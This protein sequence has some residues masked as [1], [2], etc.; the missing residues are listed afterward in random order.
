MLSSF[1]A[2]SALILCF[3]GV[4]PAAA[5]V[6]EDGAV[7]EEI[8]VMAQRRNE[9]LQNVPV[10]VQAF[11]ESALTSAGVSSTSD[12]V[13][14]AP[15]LTF[16]AQAGWAQPRLRGVGTIALGPGIENPVATY[17]DGVYFASM[18][19][20][21]LDL[22]NVEAVEVINGP[23]GTLFGRNATGGLVQIRTKTPSHNFGGHVS[24]TYGN[25]ETFGTQ[26][27]VTGGLTDK[28]AADL[29]ISYRN[30]GE[31]YGKN[32]FTGT[33]VEKTNNYYIRSKILI[34]PSDMTKI[35]LAGDYGKE[36]FM[37]VLAP[38]PGTIPTGGVPYTGPARGVDGYYDPYG[39][40]TQFGGS[41]TIE[42]DFGVLKLLSITAY[43]KTK[44]HIAFDGALTRDPN[45]ALN[46][47]PVEPH[48]QF[49]QELQILSPDG[50]P[51]T[52]VFGGYYFDE[53]AKFD[54]VLLYGG[55]FDPVR[56]IEEFS[57]SRTSSGSVYGQAT[58]EILPDTN[59]TIGARYI[60]EK[61]KIAIIENLYLADGT[62]IA[63]FTT[64]GA[65]TFQKP[66][67]RVSLDHKITED[68]MAYVSYNRG[69]KSGGF[70]TLIFPAESFA[71]ERLDAYEVGLKT[72]LFDHSLRV[73]TAAFY[74]DYKNIQVA[75]YK[76][77]ILDIYNGAAATLYGLDLDVEWAATSRLTLKSGLSL[78]H[79]TFDDF[80]DA[81][82]TSPTPGG[83][84]TY[85]VGSAKDNKLP[86]APDWTF[87]IAADYT[88][89]TRY[90][91]VTLN[92][93]YL[94]NAG[95]Y[96]EPDNRLSQGAYDVLN[97]QLG[98]TSTDELYEL[99]IWAKNITNEDYATTVFS[100]FNGDVIQYA[101]P[102]TFGVTLKR[103]F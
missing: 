1:R 45:L 94:H 51:I 98:W 101:P 73:N 9:N 36:K 35:T 57:T 93:T 62:N 32:Y 46:I 34:A 81:D 33:E 30:Q 11:N 86:L 27:Y 26:A 77:G 65:K 75:S 21:T 87:N 24:A 78:L 41:A 20:G 92:L 5:E 38:A 80:P 88:V 23:Q 6:A 90:G 97:G 79:A 64:D 56:L 60:I 69:F 42:H 74:Y 82:L 16:G 47:E 37:P 76:T 12:L 53:V 58:A 71:P 83:G 102:R 66:T 49:S 50:S 29:A 15:S 72:N 2:G 100:Q 103:S 48:R 10:A 99:R 40:T 95:W 18:A 63:Q 70:N 84:T 25:Y 14:L 13:I 89:P 4:S 55:I 91:D 8:T 3:V 52:W 96:G 61:R 22:S 19:G 39:R 17:V 85:D 54:P 43:R 31:G 28:V 68:I 67:W 44:F 59:L 7:I